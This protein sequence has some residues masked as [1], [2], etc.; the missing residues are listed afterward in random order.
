MHKG[1]AAILIFPLM[2]M[3]FTSLPAQGTDSLWHFQSLG[4]AGFY[5]HNYAYSTYS[6]VLDSKGNPHVVFCQRLDN[7]S[8]SNYCL[9]YDSWNGTSWNRENIDYGWCACLVLDRHDNPHIT[10]ISNSDIKYASLTSSGW[11]I[12]TIDSSSE[13]GGIDLV[14]DKQENPHIVYSANSMLLYASWTSYSWIIETVTQNGVEGSL[15][16]DSNDNPHICFLKKLPQDIPGRDGYHYLNESVCYAIKTNSGWSIQTVDS[17]GGDFICLVL[18]S[19]NIPHVSYSNSFKGLIYADWN[20][21]SWDHQYIDD[22][23]GGIMS[24]D[25][26]VLDSKDNPHIAYCHD[27]VGYYVYTSWNGLNW[28]KQVI[29]Q[30]GIGSFTGYINLALDSNNNPHVFYGT[31][32]D[33]Y[34]LYEFNLTYAYA[35]FNQSHPTNTF[36]WTIAG[37]ILAAGTIVG[38]SVLVLFIY[39]RNKKVSTPL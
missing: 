25:C 12:Q 1:I 14:L 22:S 6:L 4:S 29:A 8:E 7:N 31:F 10:Y 16:L 9:I 23:V 15:A 26:L 27:A 11:I 30:S 38:A 37:V 13:L 18:D 17:D 39:R 36:P 19:K 35:D 34:P 3:L 20:G 21:T 32:T 33:L 2:M 5:P 28:T 24:P